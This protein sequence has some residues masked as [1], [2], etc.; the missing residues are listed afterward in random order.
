MTTYFE[1]KKVTKV[2]QFSFS[3]KTEK[4]KCRM[5]TVTQKVMS[6]RIAR[7]T[8]LGIIRDCHSTI[9]IL[10]LVLSCLDSGNSLSAGIHQGPF[11]SDFSL[12]LRIVLLYSFRG[13]ER[14][15]A[16]VTLLL[17]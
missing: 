5:G 11:K 4:K 15:L 6:S 2:V 13:P 8:C 16:R 9:I 12:Q 14:R 17:A 1:D 10:S 7:A 3:E